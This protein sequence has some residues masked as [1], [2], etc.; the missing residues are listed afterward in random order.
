MKNKKTAHFLGHFPATVGYGISKSSHDDQHEKTKKI[1]ISDFLFF[2]LH[3]RD[4][5]KTCC[6]IFKNYEYYE[7]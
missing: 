6:E 2:K 4:I 7:K 5:C 1:D 3:H